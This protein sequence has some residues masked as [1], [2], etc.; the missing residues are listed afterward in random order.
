MAT[1]RTIRNNAQGPDSQRVTSFAE[2]KSMYV[3]R[4]TK[5]H[6]PA[7]ASKTPADSGGTSTQHYAPQ[8]TTDREWYDN[9]KF[10]GEGHIHHRADHCESSNPSWPLGQWL[11]KPYQK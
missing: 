11:D 8:Y 2:A 5:E 10:P 3:H 7:W 4:F 1:T 6:V 9:T